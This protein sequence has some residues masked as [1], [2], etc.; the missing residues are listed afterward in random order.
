M[1]RE[2]CR[3][4]MGRDGGEPDVRGKGRKMPTCNFTDM[5]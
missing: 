5:G 4:R 2:G 3:E 1:Q